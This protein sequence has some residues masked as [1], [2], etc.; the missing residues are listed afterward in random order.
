MT[1][2]H[3]KTYYEVELLHEQERY[4]TEPVIARLEAAVGMV[5]NEAQTILDIGSGNGTFLQI[6]EERRPGLALTGLERS[7][8]GVRA[9]RCNAPLIQ[10]TADSLPFADAAFELVSC[11]N[12]IEHLPYGAYER[13]LAEV[14]RVALIY[15]LVSVPYRERRLRTVCPYCACEFNPHY[16]MRS[17]GETTLSGLF[18]GFGIAA[19]A[20]VYCDE[21]FLKIL[22]RPFRRRIFS[23]FPVTALCPQCGYRPGGDTDIDPLSEKSRIDSSRSL[24]KAIAEKLP[25]LRVAR[26]I[27]VLFEKHES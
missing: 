20:K 23:D 10:G 5:P 9:A 3:E 4:N 13:V 17:Y 18:P 24:I 8:A 27:I 14:R 1:G 6:L 15:I 21:S 26:D 2:H 19:S 16:H 11:L 12:M 22:A 25:T 7:A